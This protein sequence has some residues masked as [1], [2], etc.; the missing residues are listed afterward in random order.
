MTR[1]IG[2]Q[3]KRTTLFHTSLSTDFFEPASI[4]LAP[5]ESLACQLNWN[6]S[7]QKL[8]TSSWSHYLFR[9]HSSS[10]DSTPALCN[11]PYLDK[12]SCMLCGLLV[13]CCAIIKKN[14]TNAVDME[15][16]MKSFQAC[17]IDLIWTFKYE[18]L[19]DPGASFIYIP[20][21]YHWYLTFLCSLPLSF[22]VQRGKVR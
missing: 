2:K 19:W 13:V 22:L 15:S 12:C 7:W 14:G 20:L 5:R 16:D 17:V 10:F 1:K 3:G 11:L 8:V 21:S 6:C 9:F 18:C 4:N